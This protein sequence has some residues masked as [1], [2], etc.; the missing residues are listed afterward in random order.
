MSMIP[1]IQVRASNEQKDFCKDYLAK[2]G[3]G[4][5]GNF[6]GNRVQQLFGLEAQVVV[7][8]L[9]GHKRP[10][11][12]EGFDGGYDLE[13]NG[14]RYDVKC[15]MR[16]TAFMPRKYV[17]NLNGAQEHYK[18]DGYIFVSY[19]ARIGVFEIC[20]FIS[21]VDFMKNAEHFPDG[22]ERKRADGTTF[23]VPNRGGLYEL[24]Q[25][26]LKPLPMIGVDYA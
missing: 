8:D 24:N 5:R 22:A 18:T 25:K 3:L 13:V 21:K 15:E 26:F 11:H 12:Q 7:G 16:T 10:E 1:I 2:G 4:H 17:H 9:L 19:N 23:K 20:G 6:D 14:R